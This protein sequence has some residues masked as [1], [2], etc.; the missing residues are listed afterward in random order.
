MVVSDL[1]YAVERLAH[2][3]AGAGAAEPIF[4]ALCARARLNQALALMANSLPD[5]YKTYFI[6]LK[7]CFEKNSEKLFGI[8]G[9]RREEYERIINEQG[10]RQTRAMNRLFERLCLMAQDGFLLEGLQTDEIL[11]EEGHLFLVLFQD[12]AL[13]RE[14]LKAALA[15]QIDATGF[16]GEFDNFE[17]VFVQNTKYFACLEDLWPALA[18]RQFKKPASWLARPPSTCDVYRPW[19]DPAKL[20]SF[21]RAFR[22]EAIAAAKDCEMAQQTIALG[23]GF[24]EQD[25]IP[26]AYEHLDSCRFCRKLLL[27]VSR[28]SSYDLDEPTQDINIWPDLEQAL[29]IGGFR[30]KIWQRANSFKRAFA[31]ALATRVLAGLLLIMLLFAGLWFGFGRKVFLGEIVSPPSMLPTSAL[32]EPDATAQP[33]IVKD[34]EPGERTIGIRLFGRSARSGAAGGVMGGLAPAPLPPSGFL[35]SGDSFQVHFAVDKASFVFVF[36]LDSSG[37]ISPLLRG[38]ASAGEYFVLPGINNWYTLDNV[39]GTETVWVLATHRPIP[40]F[41]ERLELLREKGTDAVG[42]VFPDSYRQVFSFEHRP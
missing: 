23:K 21:A 13:A 37:S 42:E 31:P 25:K 24:L 4:R 11:R 26:Q 6:K 30:H 14:E 17:S 35:H 27:D 38:K 3:R 9:Q 8:I 22:M 16:F 10:I 32:E 18:D 12:L 20:E 39:A 28:A 29:G 5:D 2:I 41:Y 7:T 40:D 34:F 19:P 15:G 33:G 36:F 1:D